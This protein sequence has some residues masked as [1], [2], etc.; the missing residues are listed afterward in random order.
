MMLAPSPAGDEMQGG[1]T[2]LPTGNSLSAEEQKQ[3]A[4]ATIPASSRQ[5]A[6]AFWLLRRPRLLAALLFVG[7]TAAGIAV[8][9]PHLRAWYH[10]RAARSEL[11]RWHNAQAIRHLQVCHRIWPHD[12]DVLILAAQSA[13][14]VRGYEEAERLLK[15]YQDT[16]GLDDAYSLEQLLL[17]AERR[18]DQVADLCF[19]YVDEGHPDTPLILEALTLGYLQQ[20]RLGEA[21][22]CLDRWLQLYPD[23]PQALCL[24]GVY[25]LDYGHARSAAERSYRRVLELDPEHEEA[26]LGLAVA[27]LDDH[28]YEDA[29]QHLEYL[30]QCQPDNLSIQVGLADCL[31]GLDRQ[32][33]AVQIADSVLAQNPDFVPGLSLRGRLAIKQDQ[34]VEAE[35]WLH[36]AVRL[37][38]NDHRARVAL[39]QAL[40]HNGKEQEAQQ[41]QNLLDQLE[42]DL[43]RFNAIVTKEMVQRPRDPALHCELGQLLIRSGQ[44]ERG[45]HYLTNALRL[46]PQYAPARQALDNYKQKMEAE[47]RQPNAGQQSR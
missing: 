25:Y 4:A 14:R 1:A 23:H 27:L 3:E 43:T 31:E 21:R 36:K 20:Y 33:E 8:I 28:N 40:N 5:K 17:S 12:P 46:D 38:P 15:E 10:L 34:F 35:N 44:N 19:H 42:K 41:Q 13:R 30:R 37:N 29:A 24:E 32:A 22:L 2:G 16:R 45:L 9:T 26:R 47:A 6:I 18:L 39:V 11:R 7:L